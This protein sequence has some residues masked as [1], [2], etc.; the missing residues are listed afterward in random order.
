MAECNPR[1]AE[2]DD[3]ALNESRSVPQFVSELLNEGVG[4]ELNIATLTD[5]SDDF[6]SSEVGVSEDI[7]E[8]GFVPLER[9]H[10]VGHF[11]QTPL[12]ELSLVSQI[13]K[14]R[15]TVVEES[16][17]LREQKTQFDWVRYIHQE[18]IPFSL[19]FT[20]LRLQSLENELLLGGREA[21]CKFSHHK[22]HNLDGLRLLLQ[23]CDESVSEVVPLPQR[24]RAY[25][26][27]KL[28]KEDESEGVERAIN[29]NEEQ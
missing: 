3:V 13:G 18:I 7:L 5:E 10:L 14:G 2:S 27:K 24:A 11:N 4:E 6:P 9:E 17:E 8:V 15:V 28:V 29:G 23:Q 21:L 22:E 20:E 19:G 25:Q 26:R 16:E 12:E 1:S